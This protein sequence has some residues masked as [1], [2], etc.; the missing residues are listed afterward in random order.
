MFSKRSS[1]EVS[2]LWSMPC[3]PVRLRKRLLQTL[4]LQVI[5]YD[6]G[7]IKGRQN[8]L[9]ICVTAADRS[10]WRKAAQSASMDTNIQRTKIGIYTKWKIT[11]FRK[12]YHAI[13]A[14]RFR[15][16]PADFSDPSA[17]I[18]SYRRRSY[19]R[20]HK[21]FSCCA[22]HFAFE[23]RWRDVFQRLLWRSLGVVINAT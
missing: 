20:R 4:I 21:C 16:I 13:G 3:K 14:V 6:R 22:V 5:L 7:L 9:H 1:G 10:Y 12:K 19:A 8:V 11:L 18:Y 17:E 2:V 23:M 15:Y